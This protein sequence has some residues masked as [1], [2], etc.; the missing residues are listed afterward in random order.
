VPKI[1][2]V[3]KKTKV[4]PTR[5][6]AI[7]QA[8]LIIAEYA[9][10]GY[11]LT[12]RQLYYQFVARGLIPN[13]IKEYNKLG[14][15]I[16]EGRMLGLIDWNAI[17]DRTR[18]VKKNTHWD[19]PS[20]IITVC[21]QT[22]QID[23][24]ARQPY[25]CEVWIEKDALVGVIEGICRELDVSYL[26]CRGYAS[27][28]EI[29]RAGHKRLLPQ[30]ESG[31]K[32]AIKIF[33]L[34]DH[35]PSGIDMTRDVEDRLKTF[36]GEDYAH[37]IE[38]ERLALNYEQVQEHNPPPNPTKLTDSRAGKYLELYGETCW[39][40]DALSPELIASL[41]QGAVLDVRDEALWDEAVAEEKAYRKELK[42][43]ATHWDAMV[44]KLPKPTKQEL[45][46]EQDGE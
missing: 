32:E 24:W 13:N 9:A 12:L 27:M 20:E 39:E 18:S 36:V 17:V 46:E 3:E 23:K 37:M 44:K 35:D 4:H 8:N 14:D 34:G 29:W 7:N 22:F 28:S 42:R 43:M 10:M 41:I 31:V 40:L 1:Q 21:A 45:E 19:D 26:A 30:C 2:Y 16:S 15:A 11:D 25:H 5:L 38:V 33:Y 6:A